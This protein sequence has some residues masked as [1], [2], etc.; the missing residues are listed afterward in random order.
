MKPV[1][2]LSEIA[3][4]IE[5]SGEKNEIPYDK[6]EL[7]PEDEK[8][9]LGDVENGLYLEITDDYNLIPEFDTDLDYRVFTENNRH[10]ALQISI[11]RDV[12]TVAYL[13]CRVFFDAEIKESGA[14]LVEVS[15]DDL[16]DDAY[17]AMRILD[18]Q[19][20][21]D[22]DEGTNPY[23]LLARWPISTVYLQHIAVR[24]D[25]R[26]RGLGGWL[27]RNLPDILEV[28]C[29]VCPNVIIVKIYPESVSWKYASPSFTADLGD[30]DENGE[31]F[32][33]M[34]KLFESCGYSRHGKSFFFIRD[35]AELEIAHA[36]YSKNE[37]ETNDVQCC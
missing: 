21:L 11:K 27:L 24:E 35:F 6:I 4:K 25:Y 23:F 33:V 31:M 17:E 7:P 18:E 20:L 14:S 29:K 1:V 30:P 37:G 15:D 28:H 22:R 26:G 2:K 8:T 13:E 10:I 32:S 3:G 9:R 5:M 16:N 12:E 36:I 34:R 19:G